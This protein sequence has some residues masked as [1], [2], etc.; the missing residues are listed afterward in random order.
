[1][2]DEVAKVR[3]PHLLKQ[4]HEVMELA[5]GRRT[6]EP[7]D[8]REAIAHW[9][10]VS[11]TKGVDTSLVLSWLETSRTE[12]L[13]HLVAPFV[14]YPLSRSLAHKN[15]RTISVDIW[16]DGLIPSDMPWG[17]YADPKGALKLSS[18]PRCRINEN[19]VGLGR[20]LWQLRGAV[21]DAS[22]LHHLRAYYFPDYHRYQVSDRTEL[23]DKFDWPLGMRSILMIPLLQAATPVAVVMF[24]SPLRDFLGCFLRRPVEEFAGSPFL[25]LPYRIR[26]FRPLLVDVM[27]L[28]AHAGPKDLR[29]M[30]SKDYLIELEKEQERHNGSP[31]WW[32]VSRPVPGATTKEVHNTERPTY[33]TGRNPSDPTGGMEQELYEIRRTV[34]RLSTHV[35]GLAAAL[36][37]R[38]GLHHAY[39]NDPKSL[40]AV[41]FEHDRDLEHYSHCLSELGV[42][43]DVA[44]GRTVVLLRSDYDLT[45]DAIVGPVKEMSVRRRSDPPQPAR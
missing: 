22:K 45:C 43:W 42:E 40:V 34:S 26:E 5:M 38:L 27:W 4:V 19:G 14:V 11:D 9:R 24:Y 17:P 25:E 30:P 21:H 35:E 18:Q 32:A 2:V 1:M 10:R 39:R 12:S 3:D 15:F 36:D 41:K 44:G 16:P 20:M 7:P 13:E 6:P 37:P 29:K 8:V 33:K 28:A 31:R 23:P